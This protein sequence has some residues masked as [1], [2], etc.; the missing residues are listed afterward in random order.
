[1]EEIIDSAAKDNTETQ[2]EKP[3]EVLAETKTVELLEENADKSF[4]EEFD[5]PKEE[6]KKESEQ[7]ADKPEEKTALEIKVPEGYA[8]ADEAIVAKAMETFQAIGMT[9]TQIDALMPLHQEMLG[10]AL[11]QQGQAQADLLKTQDAEW[12]KTLKEDPD[13]GGANFQ[14]NA[15]LAVRTLRK[16]G[17]NELFE[18]INGSGLSSFPPLVK[19]L[20][21]VGKAISE[22]K[23]PDGKPTV[24]GTALYPSMKDLK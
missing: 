7:P 16:F 20:S 19:M 12:R 21:R 9:Q 2:S 14:A 6:P 18:M 8:L 23:I 5:E 4:L 1:V 24:K 3:P 17:D 10:K 22:D 11:A 13:F 15:S